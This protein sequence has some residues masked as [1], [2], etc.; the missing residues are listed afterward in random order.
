MP[1]LY[2]T[3]KSFFDG[4]LPVV[5]D[6]TYSLRRYQGSVY[7]KLNDEF[8]QKFT[9]Q[10][11]LLLQPTRAKYKWNHHLYT[12]YTTICFREMPSL[13]H[14][15]AASTMQETMKKSIVELISPDANQRV[16][17]CGDGCTLP[18]S[19]QLPAVD[20]STFHS[21]L[22]WRTGWRFGLPRS[23]NPIRDD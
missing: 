16:K 5:R 17:L 12:N 9:Y 19:S 21:Q 20:V 14:A 3:S 15:S 8:S 18:Y 22:C 10:E 4:I 6:L 13:S 2:W 1:T 7:V 23:S 11:L